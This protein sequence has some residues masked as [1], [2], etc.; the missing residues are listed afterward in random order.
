MRKI[1]IFVCTY[2]ATSFA[3]DTRP[4]NSDKLPLWEAGAGAI[5]VKFPDYPGSDQI[6][7]WTIPFPTFLYRGKTFRAGEDGR[8]K[9]RFLNSEKWEV[10]FSFGGSLPAKSS[11]NPNRAGMENLDTVFEIGPALF[12]HFQRANR[13][14]SYR[15]YIEIPL[16]YATS[17]DF[18][19]DEVRDKGLVFHPYF[20]FAHDNLLL[21][22]STIFFGIG[23]FFATERYHDNLYEIDPGEATPFRPLYNA[24]GGFLS[25][26]SNLGFGYRPLKSEKLN[27][28]MGLRYSDYHQAKNKDSSLHRAND[29]L[30]YA[31]GF[32]W[33][34]FESSKK[35]S[36]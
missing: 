19:P 29:Y 24:R 21:N 30:S 33:R 7:H 11:D 5:F 12:W 18:D 2:L 34:F 15:A 27:L 9:A 22:R 3:Q 14:K 31:I 6:R 23:P 20:H 16:R 10:D 36:D 28:F 4:V 35:G 25:W 13:G 17:L 26:D 1:L 8:V 32:S